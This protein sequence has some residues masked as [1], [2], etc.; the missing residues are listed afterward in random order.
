[1]QV[2]RFLRAL[3]LG[4]VPALA[5][6]LPGSALKDRTT[7]APADK[8]RVPAPLGT[9]HHV[10]FAVADAAA[11]VKRLRAG[12]GNR[13]T[14]V[15]V[16]RPVVTVPGAGT[17]RV[18]IRRARSL[19]GAP[20][21][22]LIESAAPGPWRAAADRARPFLSY[23]VRDVDQ[24]GGRLTYAGLRKVASSDA[25]S[26][27]EGVGGVLVQLI[28]DGA[29]PWGDDGR[30]SGL[31]LGRV[32]NLS[33]LPCAPRAVKDQLTALSGI[34][35]TPAVSYDMP[36]TL[37]DGTTVTVHETVQLGTALDPYVSIVTQAP[38]LPGNA[39]SDGRTPFYPVFLTA[40]V[41][42]ASAQLRKAGFTRLAASYPLVGLYRAVGI[43]VEVAHVSFL[44]A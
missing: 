32:R 34:T 36:W 35:W 44:P 40:D 21:I 39:C 2:S 1:M 25:F 33:I 20:H 12:T 26:F 4:V 23:T 18:E 22:E 15:R 9:P 14:P 3:M 24:A 6:A 8:H 13:F 7:P 5:L 42:A 31:D 41:T 16:S 11:A 38:A 30:P 37:G 10:G 19:R 28:E 43:S 29:A 27:W 17:G